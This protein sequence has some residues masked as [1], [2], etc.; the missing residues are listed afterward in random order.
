MSEKRHKINKIANYQTIRVRNNPALNAMTLFLELF[1]FGLW[2]NV[3]D[4]YTNPLARP[5]MI[6]LQVVRTS[7]RFHLRECLR[8]TSP[9]AWAK[10]RSRW[11]TKRI[12]GESVGEF[13]RTLHSE[14]GDVHENVAEKQTPH[15]F[16]STISKISQVTLLVK[17][18]EL[19]G[20]SWREGT[21]PESR[22]RL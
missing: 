22:Q 13:L 11:Q 17:R 3:H 4:Q 21:S 14:N 1:I 15:P 10:R 20:W 7:Y 5:L 16:N 9:S 6:A 19:I 8:N 18:R 2:R 12:V